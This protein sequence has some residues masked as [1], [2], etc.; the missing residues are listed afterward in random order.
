MG[1]CIYCGST[2]IQNKGKD[3]IN[4][5]CRNCMDIKSTRSL[6]NFLIYI[7]E[8]DRYRWGK[9]VDYN[10]RKRSE[11]AIEVRK[12]RDS[13]FVKKNNWTDD[14]T[15]SSTNPNTKLAK[16]RRA[17]DKKWKSFNFEGT[18]YQTF[19]FIQ[20]GNNLKKKK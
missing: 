16:W 9:V 12:I 20:N 2:R 1:Q 5:T 14:Y 6:K 7:L 13:K 19:D 10:K 11:I 17:R 8:N 3:T 4:P 18:R 15:K